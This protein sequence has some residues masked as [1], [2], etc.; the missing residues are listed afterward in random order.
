MLQQLGYAVELAVDADAALALLAGRRFDLV[1]SDIIMA[2]SMDGI[3][4]ARLIRERHP[5]LP[6][7]LVTGYAGADTALEREFTVLRKP[8]KFAE[9]SRAVSET[10]AGAPSNLIRLDDARRK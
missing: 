1:V 7:M 4:L 6:V 10:L 9:L 2:G 3:A 5:R 8:Y